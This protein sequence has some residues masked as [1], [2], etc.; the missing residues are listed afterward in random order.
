[1]VEAAAKRHSDAPD[2]FTKQM[3]ETAWRNANQYLACWSQNLDTWIQNLASAVAYLVAA[4]AVAATC[5]EKQGQEP[6]LHPNMAEYNFKL[7]QILMA[8]QKTDRATPTYSAAH[9]GSR[10]R[11]RLLA[12]GRFSD[13]EEK[14]GEP[15]VLTAEQVRE[16]DNMQNEHQVVAYITPF[17]E[18]SVTGTAGGSVFN[19]EHYKWIQTSYENCAYNDKPDLIII[20]PA[21]LTSKPPFKCEKDQTLKGMRRSGDKFGA[22]AAWKLR[23]FIGLTCEAKQIIDDEAFGEVVNYGAHIC[24]DADGHGSVS[25]RL[26]LFDKNEFWLVESV[27][28]AVASVLKSGWL[29]PGSKHILHDFV[30]QPTLAKLLN[31]ACKHFNVTVGSDSFLGAGAFGH[32]FRAQRVDGASVALKI[33]LNLEKNV[34]RL[35]IEVSRTLRAKQ[36]CPDEVVGLEEDGF[37]TFDDDGADLLLSNVGEHFLELSEQSIVDS[38]QR[39]HE[40]GIVH[41]DAR[42]ENVVCVN[43][44]PRWID[45]ADSDILLDKPQLMKRDGRT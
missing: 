32:V 8:V 41:G 31:V 39:L 38:L 17:L 29:V 1:M 3:A 45:F 34:Q 33:A 22:L 27:K 5:L 26:L 36:A 13:F 23:D 42:P 2:A 37:A 30:R 24:Y 28:G 35:G 44:K 19:S 4:R 43:G 12:D 10:I 21:F 18:E 6:P 7:D 20:H 15:S 40:S 9:I 16:L 14:T 11:K 25:A